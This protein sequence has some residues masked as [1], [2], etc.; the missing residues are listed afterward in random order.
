MAVAAH[1]PYTQTPS[2]THGVA[3][4]AKTGLRAGCGLSYQPA[5]PWPPPK[6]R[7]RTSTQSPE[8]VCSLAE[9]R[10]VYH[11]GVIVEPDQLP[12]QAE[13]CCTNTRRLSHQTRHD[14]VYMDN[15]FTMSAEQLLAFESARAGHLLMD[16][17]SPLQGNRQLAN[18]VF[19]W[20]LECINL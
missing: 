14:N 11:E 16:S 19:V 4:W 2:H 3:H 20:E 6:N 12:H 1:H 18:R 8:L 17:C 10:G 5:L 13:C 9:G 15:V 7:N